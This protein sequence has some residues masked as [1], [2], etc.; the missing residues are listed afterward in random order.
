MHC[1]KS[2]LAKV[3]TLLIRNSNPEGSVIYMIL[4]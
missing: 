3:V 2:I 1:Q 4:I